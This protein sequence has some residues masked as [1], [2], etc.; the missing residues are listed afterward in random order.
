MEWNPPL[1]LLTLRVSPFSTLWGSTSGERLFVGGPQC[2]VDEG[3]GCGLGELTNIS[4][5]PKVR[6]A[7][8]SKCI[9]IRSTSQKA[10]IITATSN[11]RIPAIRLLIV[12]LPGFRLHLGRL[13]ISKGKRSDVKRKKHKQPRLISPVETRIHH[14]VTLV[15]YWNPNI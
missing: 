9:Y 10:A 5:P 8:V 13:E 6:K 11:L 7:S 1:D 15:D 4:N 3:N 14:I 12:S 2:R